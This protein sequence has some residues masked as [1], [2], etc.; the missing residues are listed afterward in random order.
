MINNIIRTTYNQ[1]SG[2]GK[3]ET[4]TCPQM[5]PGQK[6]QKQTEKSGAEEKQ[7]LI[8][9]FMEKIN[10]D[11]DSFRLTAITN[12]LN[13]GK[14]LSYYELGYLRQRD[15]ALYA[16]AKAIQLERKSLER[17]LT[18]CKNKAQLRNLQHSKIISISAGMQTKD[19]EG[20]SGYNRDLS[21]RIA[22]TNDTCL[23]YRRTHKLPET[24]G[25]PKY[26]RL[27]LSGKRK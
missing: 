27:I 11:S 9:D 26:D 1:Y 21:A 13:S 10:R 14:K 12:K 22:S 24:G 23:Q 15:A 8:T 6:N 17:R 25:R 3:A 7:A 18:G 5:D 19:G 2:S 4:E 20:A 16:K